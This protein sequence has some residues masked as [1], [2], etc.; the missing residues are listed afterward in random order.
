M[1]RRTCSYSGAA[2][3]LLYFFPVDDIFLGR[4]LEFVFKKITRH[5]KVYE[6]A[7]ELR[8]MPLQSVIKLIECLCKMPRYQLIKIKDEVSKIEKE[9]MKKYLKKYQFTVLYATE[10]ARLRFVNISLSE[11][12][13]M[14]IYFLNV[15]CKWK[16]KVCHKM[17]FL[18]R[19]RHQAFFSKDWVKEHDFVSKVNKLF[20]GMRPRG[21]GTIVQ[22]TIRRIVYFFEKEEPILVTGLKLCQ[23]TSKKKSSFWIYNED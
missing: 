10:E 11:K 13:K 5:Q 4:D 19:V 18:P 9:T 2:T 3:Y 16:A 23:P 20:R 15:C 17:K 6:G 12:K 14:L 8:K 1:K 7:Q 22:K 21:K